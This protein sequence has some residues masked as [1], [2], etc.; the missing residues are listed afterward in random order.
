MEISEKD[1]EAT[2]EAVL[3]MGGPDA[4]VDPRALREF[5]PFDPAFQPGGYHRRKPGDYNRSLCLIPADVVAFLQATQP[6]EW[7]KLT[8]QYGP[9]TKPRFLKRLAHGVEHRGVVDVLRKGVKDRGAKFELAYFVPS[10]GLN[11]ELQRMYRANLFSVVRQLHFSETNEKSLDVVLFL[12]GLPLFTAELKNPL[13]GQNVMNAVRQY[14]R[15][16]DPHEPLFQFGRCLAH[17]AVDPDL[18]YFSSHLEGN[19]TVFF[20]FNRGMNGGAGNPAILGKFKTAYLWEQV[21]ARDSVLNLIQHFVHTLEPLA[22]AGKSRPKKRLIFPRYHQLT[23]VRGIITHARAQ[24]P[25]QRYLVQHSAGSGKSFSIAWLAHQLSILHDEHDQRVFDSIIV[26]T[27]RRVLDRQLQHVVAQ[28]EQVRGLVENIDTTSKHLKQALEEG[29]QIIVTTL[30]KF[31]Y[32][33]DQVESLAGQSFALVIDEAHSS[34]TGETARQMKEVLAAGDLDQAVEEDAAGMEPD[35]EDRIIAE[36]KKRGPLKNVSSFA[37]T[38]TPKPKTLEMFGTPTSTGGFEPFSL[39]SMRQAIE[40]NFILD[41]LE[42]YTTYQTY[43]NLLK[44]AED[45]PR[46]DKQKATYLLKRFVELHEHTIEQKVEIMVEHFHNNVQALIKR[47]AKAMIV[48]RSRLHAVRTKLAV[49][50][51]LREQ[52]Y[53]YKALVAFSGT[54][55][56]GGKDFTE[57]NMNSIPET[58][59]AEEFNQDDYRFLIVAE[60]FQTGFDQPLLHTMYVDKTLTGLHAVQTLSRL[61]RTH[62]DKESTFVLDFANDAEVIQKAFEPYYEKTA[63]SE[64]TDPNLLY[65]YEARIREVHLFGDDDLNEFAEAYFGGKDTQQALYT[66]F[67]PVVKRFVDLEEDAQESFRKALKDFVRLYAFLSHVVTFTDPDLEKLYHFSRYLVR[68]LPINQEELPVEITRQI[69]LESFRIQ[70]TFEGDLSLDRGNGVLDP[71]GGKELGDRALEEDEV[72]SQIIRELNDRFGT[73]FDEKDAVVIQA[74]VDSLQDDPALEASAA[75]NTRENV[76]LT[77]EQ[78]LRDK[79]QDMI[80][81][82]FRF[83]KHVNDDEAVRKFLFDLLFDRYMDGLAGVG[84]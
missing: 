66:A 32:I 3:L 82:H 72:L 37:F 78:V 44:T 60:K 28:F 53:P 64:A 19:K 4:P 48:T 38:A 6:E 14:R 76:R 9:E 20:P 56:D 59:T 70:K 51:Y 46:Y 8:Q 81:T 57:T 67:D 40:E 31:P 35:L 5:A 33:I 52:G 2:I 74:L 21:W 34:Q 75:V 49:D 62:P 1:F 13:N 27:D 45:D 61:N 84:D 39:Y 12:N 26:V 29:K 80:D 7:G 63:L 68:K 73:D 15:D 42:N 77:F 58:Q 47:K 65:D 69:D 22:T 50:R 10:S 55:K 25:S 83:Y 43:W 18:V 17:F 11:P 79:L 36:M 30:Q 16:R 23:A 71:V 54:V 24:G 41:V